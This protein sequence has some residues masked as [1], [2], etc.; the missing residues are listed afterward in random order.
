M[1]RFLPYIQDPND[2][3]TFPEN[4]VNMRPLEPHLYRRLEAP[5]PISR[6]PHRLR[7][8]FPF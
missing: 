8:I 4:T 3:T 1:Y 7:L 6:L 2:P 5:W